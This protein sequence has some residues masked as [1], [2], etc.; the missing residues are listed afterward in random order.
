M[1]DR[2]VQAGPSDSQKLRDHIFQQRLWIE[3]LKRTTADRET[4][5]RAIIDL[6]ALVTKVSEAIP[7]RNRRRAES[8]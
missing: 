8:S 1:Q 5:R 3:Q 2:D 6:Q 7:P 4:L